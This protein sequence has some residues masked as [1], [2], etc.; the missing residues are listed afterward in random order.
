[1]TAPRTA[2]VTINSEV[3]S[4]AKAVMAAARGG[5]LVVLSERA[6]RDLAAE[7]GGYDQAVQHLLRVAEDVNKPIGVNVSTGEDTS[8]TA[9]IAPRSWSAGRLRGWVAGRHQEIEA[10]FGAAT[11]QE[12]S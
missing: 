3:V 9:F 1:M 12:A 6:I 11:V 7:L 8:S 10:A 5:P 4:P 2:T